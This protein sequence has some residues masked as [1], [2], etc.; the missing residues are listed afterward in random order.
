MRAALA[1]FLTILVVGCITFLFVIAFKPPD[2]IRLATGVRGGGYWQIG[3]LYKAELAKD[4]IA[5]EL[6]ET[7]GSIDNVRLLAAGEVDIALVQGGLTLSQ[8]QGLQSLGA[9]FLEP[10]AIFRNARTQLDPNAGEWQGL[11][12]AAG[13]VG[14]GTRAATQALIA[15]AQVVDAGIELL[16]I[17]GADA[18][19]AVRDG[20]ADAALFVAPLAAPYLMEA[21]FDPEIIFVPMSLVDALALKL[22][23]AIVAT[24]PAGSLTLDPPRPPADVKLLA[25]KASMLAG[26]DLHPALVDRIVRASI[27]LHS[28]RDI[29]HDFREYPSVDS[30]PVPVNDSAR[31][32]ILEGPNLLHNFFPYWIAAQFGSVLLLVLPVL[33]LAPP[34]L[35]SIPLAYGW[36][37]KRRIWNNYQSIG[38]LE[39]Q[40]TEAETVS[41]LE[42]VSAKLEE[43]DAVLANMK[44]PLAYRQ[45]AYDARLHVDLIRQ[46]VNRR[47]E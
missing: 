20:T 47:L 34:I 32:H 19:T 25:L 9:I 41:E 46:E 3:E 29:L 15:A 13:P 22:P 5:L 26:P 31:E 37:Q 2:N 4:D 8:N 35:Q 28:D 1:F 12:L 43:L 7:A 11:K 10:I 36:F 40:L 33:F 18:L 21:I 14:S 30:P 6:I 23:G 24:V 17:G 38:T 44:L 42:A 16:E 27:V 45:G 39:E